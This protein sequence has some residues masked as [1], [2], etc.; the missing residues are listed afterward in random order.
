MK[1]ER[2]ADHP[3]D[4]IFLKRWSPRAY[5]ASPMPQADLNSILEAARWAPSAFNVQPWRFLYSHRGDGH[6]PIFLSLLDSFNADWAK[7]ASVLVLVLS[8]SLMP[9]DKNRADK[10][11][12]YHSFD[13]GA[14]WAQLAL[15]ATSLGYHAHAMAGIHA[16]LSRT[17][18]EIPERYRVEIAIAL[19][20]RANSSQLPQTLRERELP[21]HRLP[22]SEI[23]FSGAFPQ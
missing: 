18:L 2:S 15:Q 3:I 20:K 4:P 12:N 1:I 5:D 11:S 7:H 16:G 21:S 13:T 8:D 19:G 10:L 22:I 17:S 6:W 23:A 9:G 14:A